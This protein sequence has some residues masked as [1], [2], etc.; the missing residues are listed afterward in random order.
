[1]LISDTHLHSFFS[2]DSQ[3]PMEDMV[4]QGISLGLHTLCFTEH[5]D[6]DFPVAEDGLDFQVDFE[7]YYN[8][9]IR[10]KEKYAS[11]IELLHGIELGVQP[12]IGPALA[13][14]YQKMGDRFD[15]II[16]SCHL[17]DRQDPY[18]HHFFDTRTS[19]DAIQE[20]FENIFINLRVF[21]DFQTAGHLDYICRYLPSPGY[22]FH[23]RNF[24]EI[25]DS[26]LRTL[27]ENGRGLEV[28]TAGL[29]H[30][31]PW[32]NPHMEILKRYHE[33]GG[34]II[35]IGSDAHR[36]CD[37]AYDFAKLPAMLSEAGFQYYALYRNQKP[38]F[39]PIQ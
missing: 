22:T 11:K 32:P 5:Y 27:I 38:S 14:F 34:E 30:G 25:L 13:K 39:I 8:E 35:T 3:A 4:L 18:D 23:Y 17:I 10:L 24:Q 29:K 31:L 20:Y 21:P 33:L 16:N 28:N 2:S 7:R 9:F 19:E 1:M 26:I 37:I 15:F 12:H 36:P 6:Y